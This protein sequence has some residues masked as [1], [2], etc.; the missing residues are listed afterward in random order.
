MRELEADLRIPKTTVSKILMQDLGMNPVLAKS[1][2]QLLSPEQNEHHTVLA[3]DLIQTTTKEA[4][5]LKKF[6]TGDESLVYGYDPGMKTQS[7]QLKLPG[8]PS[9]KK[10][11]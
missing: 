4:Y 10:A 7:Y 5:F 1:S 2:L 11:W 8:S 3:N 9:P 6:I